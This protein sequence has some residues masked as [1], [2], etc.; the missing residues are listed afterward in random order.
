MANITIGELTAA[1]SVSSS[2][3]IEIEQTVNG[4]QVA[5]KATIGDISGGGGGSGFDDYVNLSVAANAWS[6]Q[7]TPDM[8]GF[9]YVAT[10]SIAGVT[11][12]DIADVVPSMAAVND[13]KLCPLNKTVS[14]GV[15]IYAS[16]APS[17]AYTIERV[18]VRGSNV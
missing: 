10:I 6:L 4:Q 3:L 14:G 9:P 12:A 1:S 2:D 8:A 11:A 17:S 16:A 5:R 18:S 15:N 7:G 13:G